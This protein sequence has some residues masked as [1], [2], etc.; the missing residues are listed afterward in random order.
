MITTSYA[1][2]LQDHAEVGTCIIIMKIR[3]G[4]LGVDFFEKTEID[5]ADTVEE[6]QSMVDYLNAQNEAC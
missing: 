5:Y 2:E 4:S 1:Y 6:A 3:S